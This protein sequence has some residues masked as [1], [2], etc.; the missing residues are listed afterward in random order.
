MEPIQNVGSVDDIRC[1]LQL[2]NPKSRFEI[3]ENLNQLNYSLDFEVKNKNRISVI[4]LLQSKINK[5]KKR[6]F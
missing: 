1:T 2:I 5:L 3:R 6:W 4:R